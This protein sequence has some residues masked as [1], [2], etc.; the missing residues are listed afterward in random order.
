MPSARSA[1]YNVCYGPLTADDSADDDILASF[2]DA[3]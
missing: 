1:V 2:D 3:T